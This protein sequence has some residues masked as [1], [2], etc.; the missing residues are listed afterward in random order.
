MTNTLFPDTGESDSV[1]VDLLGFYDDFVEFQ[2]QC[3]F[4]CDAVTTLMTQ[5]QELD[6]ATLE[7]I[8]GYSTSI[9]SRM[10]TLKQQLKTIHAKSSPTTPAN[11]HQPED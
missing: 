1:H 3:A 6:K 4:F 5:H 9:K 7:G 10:L 8:C 2:S 11:L